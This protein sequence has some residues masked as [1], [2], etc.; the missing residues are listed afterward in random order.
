LKEWP[1]E[2]W[3]QL[4]R[5]ILA[6]ASP[7]LRIVVAGDKTLSF[8]IP[9]DLTARIVSFPGMLTLSELA[10][11]FE[12]SRLVIGSD[13]APLHLAACGP[14]PIIA[15]FGPT[16]PEMYA[17][18]SEHVT[19]LTGH[20]ICNRDLH[21]DCDVNPGGPGRCMAE[22]LPGRVIESIPAELLAASN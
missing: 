11:L 21:V 20:C 5:E 6:Q 1:D 7:N 2:H 14:T 10:A 16:Y 19:V 22:I 17:P 8:D 9:P 3:Q 4:A 12:R 15:L 13:S 18:F